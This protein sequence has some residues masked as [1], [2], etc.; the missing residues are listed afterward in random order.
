[1]IQIVLRNFANLIHLLQLLFEKKIYIRIKI[2]NALLKNIIY[3]IIRNLSKVLIV[4]SIDRYI[5]LRQRVLVKKKNCYHNIAPK[6][7][8]G[9]F[10][11]P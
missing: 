6:Q 9:L 11:F 10:V 2:S 3:K 1:M 7:L 5:F 8:E 4:V